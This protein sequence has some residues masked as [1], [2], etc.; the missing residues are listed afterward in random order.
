MTIDPDARALRALVVGLVDHGETHRVVH[1]LTPSGPVGCFAPA[2]RRSRRRFGGALQLFNTV[3]AHL[4]RTREG[5][6]TTLLSVEPLVLRLGLSRDLERLSLAAYLSDL[7]RR[8][9]PEGVETQLSP[10]LERCLDRIEAKGATRAERRAFE[11]FVLDELGYRPSLD[12]RCPRCGQPAAFLDLE[13]GGL[14]CGAHRDR[15]REIGPRTRAWLER[16]LAGEDAPEPPLSPEDADRAARA[17]GPALDAAIGGVLERPL[18]SA[19]M[20]AELGL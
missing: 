17:V 1:L 12:P 10:R 3:Q 13:R 20:L 9:A 18:A 16:R 19:A 6:M 7:A 15:G 4:A 14:F 11:L 2:A 8:V 5:R